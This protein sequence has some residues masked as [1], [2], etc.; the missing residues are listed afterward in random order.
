MELQEVLRGIP[1]G[2]TVISESKLAT[3]VLF[4]GLRIFIPSVDM[5]H[6]PKYDYVLV[7]NGKDRVKSGCLNGASRVLLENKYYLLIEGDLGPRCFG[8][9]RQI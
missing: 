7:E 8:N 4:P 3:L 9:V 5:V 6:L 2:K 1:E